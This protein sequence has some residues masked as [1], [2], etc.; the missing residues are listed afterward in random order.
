MEKYRCITLVKIAF[1]DKD[2]NSIPE[3]ETKLKDIEEKAA[4]I[5]NQ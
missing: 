1:D 2:K 3:L 5:T 4:K